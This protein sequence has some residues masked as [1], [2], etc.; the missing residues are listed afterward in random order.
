VSGHAS[1][2]AEERDEFAPLHS[3]TLS[4]RSTKPAGTSWPIAFAVL[5]L[6][7]SSK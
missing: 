3:I 1:R 6:I 2:A 5:R 7:T 4:A